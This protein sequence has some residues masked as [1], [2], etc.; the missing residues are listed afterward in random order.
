MVLMKQGDSCCN[1]NAENQGQKEYH[2]VKDHVC[3]RNLPILVI[4]D[5]CTKDMSTNDQVTLNNHFLKLVIIWHSERTGGA[6]AGLVIV[7]FKEL[8]Q[9]VGK[10]VIKLLVEIR[11]ATR[12]VMQE[13]IISMRRSSLGKNGVPKPGRYTTIIKQILNLESFATRRKH[14]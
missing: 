6:L 7:A 5:I 10:K 1:W 11:Q 2:E 12:M 3:L 4:W 9:W 13:Q 14:L 8:V